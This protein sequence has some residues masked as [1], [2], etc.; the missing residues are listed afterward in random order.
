[1]SAACAPSSRLLALAA[2]KAPPRPRHRTFR[3]KA[4]QLPSDSTAKQSSDAVLLRLKR[5]REYRQAEPPTAAAEQPGA[6]LQEAAAASPAAPEGEAP[7][8]QLEQYAQKQA[9]EEAGAFQ[10]AL[11]AQQAAS[12]DAAANPSPPRPLLPRTPPGL[13]APTSLAQRIRR[14]KSY[15]EAQAPPP[16]APPSPPSA[17]SAA[18]EAGGPAAA[19]AAAANDDDDDRGFRR[20]VGNAD[21]AA[22]WL[23]TISSGGR[24]ARLDTDLRPEQFTQQLE[25][26]QRERGA[27]IERAKVRV[28]GTRRRFDAPADSQDY[29]LAQQ[30][31]EAQA[32]MAA[33]R[34]RAA[35]ADAAAKDAA[36]G[37]DRVE[38]AQQAAQQAEA[39]ALEAAAGRG[40]Q[41][42]PAGATWGVFPRP[43]NISEAYGGGRNLR[44]GQQLESDEDAAAR[45]ARVSS[46]LSSYRTS[47]GLDI[48]PQVEAAC[49]ALLD[50]GETLFR[51]GA[52]AAA[53]AKFEAA[54]APVPLRSRLGGLAGLQRAITLDSLGR[55][56]EA[57]PIYVSLKGHSAPGVAKTASRMI[58]GFV[59]AKE[60]KVERLPDS[61]Q[62]WKPWFDVINQ[63]QVIYKKREGEEEEDEGAVR[64]A[65]AAA[66][67]VVLLPLALAGALVLQR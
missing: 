6:A 46:A 15:K 63:N 43:K 36:D 67:A 24:A 34:R 31:D 3:C 50:Q 48:D 14:A 54:A 49:E 17:G 41:H 8:E 56:Q 58:F 20:G 13:P 10:Q 45:A 57:Y 60:L 2:I 33:D 35:A 18:P 42:S 9:S 59:A 39:A 4:Q 52:L 26:L 16:A 37:G 47:M 7:L 28:E 27:T 25:A 30:Q 65:A 21:Q 38:R 1:M 12:A 51:A 29:G 64:A 32:E 55:N 61:S 11:Q 66:A 19:A 44:P 53:L 40:E 62:A 23:N 22:N 5:A